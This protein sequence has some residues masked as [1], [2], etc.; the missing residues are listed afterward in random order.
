MYRELSK[1]QLDDFVR[2][3]SNA[4]AGLVGVEDKME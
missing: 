2:K 3:Y 4:K 1:E